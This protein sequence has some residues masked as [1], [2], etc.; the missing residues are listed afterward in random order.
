M[1]DISGIIAC[2]FVK[3]CVTLPVTYNSL[4]LFLLSLPSLVEFMK[5][6]GL[7]SLFSL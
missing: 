7:L 6:S 3:S 5:L 2:A 4:L 1:V